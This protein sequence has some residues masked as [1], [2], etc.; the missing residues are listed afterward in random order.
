MVKSAVGVVVAPPA[1]IVLVRFG[2][3]C[4]VGFVDYGVDNHNY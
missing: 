1:H 4:G 2:I 3:G